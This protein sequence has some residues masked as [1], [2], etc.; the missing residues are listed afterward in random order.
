MVVLLLFNKAPTWTVEQL[1]DET[2]MKSDLL[3]QVL[4]SL[5]K[6]RLL[7]S[8]DICEQELDGD[9]RKTYTMRLATDF[10]R[11]ARRSRIAHERSIRL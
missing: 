1:E 4:R 11:Y 7:K 8:N 9:I 6:S 5:L 10:K 2:Q 3:N